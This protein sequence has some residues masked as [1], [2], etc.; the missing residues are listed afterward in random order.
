MVTRRKKT[1]IVLLGLVLLSQIPFAYRRYRLGRLNDAIQKT[2]FTERAPPPDLSIKKGVNHVT[3][4]SAAI[5]MDFYRANRCGPANARFRNHDRAFTKT[6]SIRRENLNE[7]EGWCLFINGNDVSTSRRDR[8]LL[9]TEGNTEQSS[10][11]PTRVIDNR[12]RER[13]CQKSL[14]TRAAAIGSV[15]GYRDRKSTTFYQTLEHEAR[16]YCLDAAMVLSGVTPISCSQL[17][18]ASAV[19]QALGDII[20]SATAESSPPPR[21]TNSNVALSID[22]MRP[23]LLHQSDP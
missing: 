4:F 19:T 20:A 12:K 6:T 1:I 8:L 5:A 2:R 9:M 21:M 16:R 11:N 15:N 7:G 18:S 10:H 3:R 23:S 22:A 13:S 17:F 14:T